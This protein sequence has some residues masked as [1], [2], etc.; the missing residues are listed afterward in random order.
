MQEFDRM[1]PVGPIFTVE[2]FPELSAQLLGMLRSFSTL[3]WQL[4]TACP[5]WSVQDV[6]AHLLGGSL[7]R[8]ISAYRQA[9][10]SKVVQKPNNFHELLDFINRQNAEWVDAAR[11]I[12]PPLLIDF[13]ELTGPKLY[14]YF[15]SL[16]PFSPASISVAWAGDDQSPVWFDIAREYTEKWLHQQHIREAAGRPLLIERKWLHPVLDTFMRALPYTYEEIAVPD[17]TA[18]W[19]SITGEAGGDWSLLRQTNRWELYSGQPDHPAASVFFGQDSAW[20]LF[21][22]GTSPEVAQSKMR[23]EG[24]HQLGSKIVQMV[25]IMA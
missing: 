23:F 15:K 25:S 13:L 2:L 18:I 12:S 4:S 8:L 9:S 16:P 17:G 19:F 24:D 21:T 1:H 7:G 5:G 22:R 10:E 11:R 3:E 14:Q 20:R 6:V